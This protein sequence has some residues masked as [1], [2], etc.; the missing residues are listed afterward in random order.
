[1]EQK[2]FGPIKIGDNVKIGAN[3]VI[4]KN[5]ESNVTVVGMPGRARTK[6]AWLIYIKDKNIILYQTLVF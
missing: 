6:E 1:V 3:A 4:L 5:V 2:Y